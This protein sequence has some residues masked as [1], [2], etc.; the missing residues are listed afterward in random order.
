[1]V[2]N[3]LQGVISSSGSLM[4]NGDGRKF[5]GGRFAFVKRRFLVHYWSSEYLRLISTIN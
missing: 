1:M 4:E 2:K 3:I 5:E